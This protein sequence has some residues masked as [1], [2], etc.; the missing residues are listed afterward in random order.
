MQNRG[1][2][3]W[4]GLEREKKKWTG[5]SLASS[6]RLTSAAYSTVADTSVGWPRQGRRQG[7]QWEY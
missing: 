3:G 5:R 4:D 2:N 6:A 7:A 1:K